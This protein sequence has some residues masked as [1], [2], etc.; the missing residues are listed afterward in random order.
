MS[1]TKRKG[2]AKLI[3]IGVVVLLL[4]GLSAWW[5]LPNKTA[6]KSSELVTTYAKLMAYDPVGCDSQ[7]EAIFLSMVHDRLL[8]PEADRE[9]LRP[10]LAERHDSSADGKTWTFHLRQAHTP[11]GVTL[12]ADD[13]IFSIQLYLHKAFQS[14]LRLS[15]LTKD[16]NGTET[17]A[18]EA[19]EGIPPVM[20]AKNERTV[21]FSTT[22]P[23][24]H[25]PA[26]IAEATILPKKLYAE[27]ADNTKAEWT[28]YLQLVREWENAGKTGKRPEF[29][30]PWQ[31]ALNAQVDEKYLRGFGPFSM[32]SRSTTEVVL[33]RNSH[34]WGRDGDGHQL[35]YLEGVRLVFSDRE[36]VKTV[37]ENDDR[38]AFLMPDPIHLKNLRKDSNFTVVDVGQAHSSTLFF[39]LNQ[40]AAV[41]QFPGKR[42]LYRDPAFRRAL[43]HAINRDTIIK[44]AMGGDA[45]PQYGPISPVYTEWALD[46]VEAK[47]L[48]PAY[49]PEK[50]KAELAKLGVT[51]PAGGE[52]L[53]YDEQGE[54]TR[55]S[56]VI[57]TTPDPSGVRFKATSELAVQL[58]RIGIDA[59]AKTPENFDLIVKD[60]MSTFNYD[61]LVMYLEGDSHPAIARAT[62]CSQ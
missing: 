45:S 36:A 21:S 62:Y 43:A 52:F 27:L 17:D 48:T 57:R 20:I 19:K 42:K 58:R 56:I 29:V 31:K 6:T 46:E 7:H 37:F 49:D 2:L 1:L 33:E 59:I 4:G 41:G 18:E 55:L 44:A 24:P 38:Y 13:V 14:S 35:P 30:S 16:P 39:W 9:G 53:E 47:S 11:D 34:F 5:L 25:F 3:A 32:S 61:A 22:Q 50:A 12:T 8:W 23:V 60:I 26:I 28:S 51:K 10:A 15:L 40:N 54:R